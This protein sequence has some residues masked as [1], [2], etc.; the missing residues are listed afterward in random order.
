MPV[1]LSALKPGD[2][3]FSV[4]R[5]KA[6]N[7]MRS[8][9]VCLEVRIL[10]VDAGAQT[11]RASSNGNPPRTVRARGGQLPWRRSKPKTP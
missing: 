11:V 5:E 1:A 10:E 2:V 9:T 8:R 3:V 7:T 6:G 4:R